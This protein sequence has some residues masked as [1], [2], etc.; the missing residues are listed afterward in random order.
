MAVLSVIERPIRSGGYG[1]GYLRKRKRVFRVL[2]DSESDTEDVAGWACGVSIEDGWESW[3]GAFTDPLCTCYDIQAEQDGENSRAWIVTALYETPASA[4]QAS[5]SQNQQPGQGN[6]DDPAQWLPKKRWSYGTLQLAMD[7]SFSDANALTIPVAN[8]AGHPFRNVPMRTVKFSVL[9]LTRYTDAFSRS[10]HQEYGNAVNLDAWNGYPA[11]QVWNSDWTVDEEYFAGNLLY[12]HTHTLNFCPPDLP[13]WFLYLLDKG[14]K[15]KDGK[16]IADRLTRDA[17]SDEW[18]M[19]GLGYFLS[20][21]DVFAKNH[22]WGRFR[23]KVA[24][25]FADVFDFTL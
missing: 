4:P 1:R 23:D 13:D 15:D 3:D 20:E 25:P 2:C 12:L 18:P 5:P 21:A 14:T 9:T 8:S 6:S 22:V 19:D 10:D 7:R 24:L 11:L 17:I 16:T